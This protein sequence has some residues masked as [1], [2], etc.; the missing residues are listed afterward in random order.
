LGGSYI[1]NE[2]KKR[3]KNESEIH[4]FEKANK[5]GAKFERK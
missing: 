1:A 2:L 5:I 4:I 3:L